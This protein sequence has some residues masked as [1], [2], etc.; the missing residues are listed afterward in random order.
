MIKKIKKVIS[1]LIVAISLFTCNCAVFAQ[2]T[3]ASSV[4]ENQEKL[5]LEEYNKKFGHAEYNHKTIAPRAAFSSVKSQTKNI[6]LSGGTYIGTVTI[7]Y[8]I[9]MESGRPKFALDTVYVSVPPSRSGIWLFYD[10]YVSYSPDYIAVNYTYMTAVGSMT[11]Y[12]TV[13]FVP[14]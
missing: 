3:N 5:S 13:G 8:Q 4:N 11:D 10:S 7:N 2:A 1:V 6:V 9:Y 12:A 14:Y